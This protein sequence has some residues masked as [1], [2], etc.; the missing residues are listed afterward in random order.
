MSEVM[1]V[2]II[3]AYCN[4]QTKG[5]E[6]RALCAEEAANCAIRYDKGI[7]TADD[8]DKL[9]VKGEQKTVHSQK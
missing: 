1:L 2:S 7:L 4:M 3:L 8:F 6:A 5:F 9:C